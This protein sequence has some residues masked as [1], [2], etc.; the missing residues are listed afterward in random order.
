MAK[1]ASQME[2]A[3]P[4][5]PKGQP[6][7]RW[8]YTSLRDEILSSRLRPGARLP[9]TRDLAR[10][11]GLARGT[12]VSAFEQLKSEG[13]IEGSVG[14]GTY[15]SDV[16][17]DEL[18]RAASPENQ[19]SPRRSPRRHLSKYARRTRLFEGYE[20]GPICAFR[21]NLPAVNLFPIRIWTHLT[22]RCWKR[23]SQAHLMGCDALGY[24]PLRR[25]VADYLVSSRGVKCEAERVAIVSG[26]QEA[27]DLVTRLLLNPGD[28]VCVEDPGYPGAVRAFQAAGA[29]LC[30][31]RQDEDG[32]RIA[33]V[34]SKDVRLLYIT[35]GHQF[36][37]GTTMS[38]AR[39][40][41]LLEWARRSGAVILEDD[42]DGEYRY[43]G[44]PIP[45]LQGL[46]PRGLV[47]YAGSFSK[48]LF[49]SLRLGY[50]VLPVDLVERVEAMKSLTNR[51]APVIDQILLTTFIEEGHFGRHLRRMREVYAERLSVL[52]DEARLRLGELVEVSPV[53][54]GLQTVGWMGSG[55]GA[56][57]AAAAALKRGV[58]VTPLQRYYSGKGKLRAGLQL[59]FAALDVRE[60]RRGVRELAIALADLAPPA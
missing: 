4:P 3:F 42:Y 1:S 11:Y 33:D 28:T 15:V 51:H 27:I 24:L 37:L 17:P 47:L 55:I 5:R 12:I 43:A 26:V 32:I 22:A 34:P 10:Q 13:Y 36:P 52:I 45:A 31:V 46:D 44:R 53:Q 60:I 40:L 54:A 59:G 25:A 23:A 48:V 8:L 50:L 14:S 41:Q 20:P 35:P 7:Y 57:A 18:L 29:R 2:K 49:P 30:T 9:A 19:R 56:E 39:R 16:L 58:V 6:A 38:L 21:A